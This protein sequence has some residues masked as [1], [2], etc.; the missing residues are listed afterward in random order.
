MFLGLLWCVATGH[1]KPARPLCDGRP[2]AS[3]HFRR[4]AGRGALFCDFLCRWVLHFALS[5]IR[6]LTVQDATS[7]LMQS[8]LFECGRPFHGLSCLFITALLIQRSQS[9]LVQENQPVK[10][11][12]QTCFKTFSINTTICFQV[13]PMSLDWPLD[14]IARLDQSRLSSSPDGSIGEQQ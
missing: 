5:L 11:F 6:C 3:P 14:P 8:S 2:F 12:D 10:Y 9:K 1:L 13:E 4:L 7:C